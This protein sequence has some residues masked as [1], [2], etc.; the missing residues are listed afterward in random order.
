MLFRQTHS[1]RNKIVTLL[2][3]LQASGKVKTVG[4]NEC[5]TRVV[6]NEN[7]V[8]VVK[9]MPKIVQAKQPTI[10]II[11]AQYCEKLAVD[12]MMDDQETFV[13]YTTVGMLYAILDIKNEREIIYCYLLSLGESN[14]YTLGNIGAHRVVC[15]KLPTV[16][17]TREA[18]IAAGST[19][20][21]LL[22]TFQAVEFVIL[23]GV[24]GG[25]PHFTDHTRHVRLGDVVVSSPNSQNKYTCLN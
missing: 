23:V 16:G 19:T 13:R 24:G 5:F 8:K 11:T 6:Q 20:T 25:V 3:E 9:Q 18:M 15:T 1:E 21:R 7:K 12:A 14:I 17:H 22:G 2:A 4:D 10:A